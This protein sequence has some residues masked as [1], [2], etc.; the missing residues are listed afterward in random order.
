VPLD[1][2]DQVASGFLAS[3]RAALD[4]HPDIAYL[5][6]Y[7]RYTGL[8]NHTYVPAGFIP[9]LSLFL[10]TDGKVAGMY[11]KAALEQV[12]GYDEDFSAFEDWDVQVALH[13]AGFQTDIIPRPGQIYRRHPESMSFTTSTPHR[14]ARPDPFLE[15]RLRAEHVGVPAGV[16]IDRRAVYATCGVIVSTVPFRRDRSA[17]KTVRCL[18]MEA[19]T[20]SVWRSVRARGDT[21]TNRSL[22]TLSCRGSPWTRC[23]VSGSGGL[24]SGP[25]QG[26]CGRHTRWCS[27]RPWGRH[28]SL[29]N[30]DGTSGG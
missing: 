26:I 15:E 8:L 24:G 6:G 13:R 18:A 29:I 25:R 10:H 1:A 3:A 30:C 27:P 17:P 16:P 19:G 22:R 20:I 12:G 7:A 21:K 4:R 11:R 9:E 23:W 28:T 5:A 14:L 2:D